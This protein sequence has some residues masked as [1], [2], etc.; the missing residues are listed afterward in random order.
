MTPGRVLLAKL[1]EIARLAHEL[2]NGASASITWEDA[3]PD[4]LLAIAQQ[5]D[6][7]LRSVDG[8]DEAEWACDGV[9][10]RVRRQDPPP[11]ARPTLRVVK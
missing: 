2:P 6:A 7:V 8:N 1:E 5:D 3:P 10:V 4:L 9:T 11:G